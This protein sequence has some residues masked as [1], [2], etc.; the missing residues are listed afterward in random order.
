MDVGLFD[1][2]ESMAKVH[3]TL[4]QYWGQL[5]NIKRKLHNPNIPGEKKRDLRKKEREI[6]IKINDLNV[7]LG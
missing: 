4:G 7:K 5:A 3:A 2:P 6:L 1:V